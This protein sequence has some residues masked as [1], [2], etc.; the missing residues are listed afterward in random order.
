[1]QCSCFLRSWRCA[2]ITLHAA[3]AKGELLLQT[4]IVE[5][6]FALLYFTMILPYPIPGLKVRNCQKNVNLYMT[7]RVEGMSP[8]WTVIQLFHTVRDDS[9]IA[10]G[11]SSVQKQH[12]NTT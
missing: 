7:V 4:V 3:A 11:L 6:V 8:L 1:M 2:I 5:G 10:Q 12:V 9:I